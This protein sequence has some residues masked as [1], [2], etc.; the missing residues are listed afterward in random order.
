MDGIILLGF[1]LTAEYRPALLD[2]LLEAASKD[3]ILTHQDI[4]EEIDTFMFEVI[5]LLIQCKGYFQKFGWFLYCM[6]SNP[7]HQ[8]YKNLNE[9]DNILILVTTIVRTA[10]MKSCAKFSKTTGTEI[11][12]KKILVG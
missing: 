4:R 2:L 10:S 5:K 8:V 11:V 3:S 12:I 6:A 1:I 7:Q 9:D